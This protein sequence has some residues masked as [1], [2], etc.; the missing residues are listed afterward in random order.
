MAE[1]F[2]HTWWGKAWVEALEERAALDP[3]RLARGRTYARQDRVTSL[4][5][6]PGLVAASVRGSQR[7][8]YRTHIEVRTYDDTEWAKVVATIARRAGHTAA[9]LDGELEPGVVDDAREAGVE[10]LPARG[11]LRPR[12]SC[13]DSAGTCKHV[14]AVAYLV[15]EVLDD[16]P[17]QLFALRG[18]TREVFLTELRA[19]RARGAGQKGATD[20]EGGDEAALARLVADKA[21]GRGADPGELARQ[22]WARDRP[23][24]PSLPE[25]PGVPGTPAAWP[26]DPPPGAPFDTPGLLTLARDAAG[27]AWA[28]LR[29]DA[30][31]GLSLS[32]D[33]DLARR[34]AD[35]DAN[36]AAGAVIG[37]A[38]D[39]SSAP[40]ASRDLTH[41]AQAWR[42]GREAG[43]AML[44]ETPWRPSV[45]T[46][47]AA[48]AAVESAGISASVLTVTNNRITGPGF[49][50]R[51]SR[52][53]Q[54]WR[55]E[56][57]KSRWEIT[58]PPEESADDLLISG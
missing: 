46:M 16:D 48:R 53:G 45:A 49:Q 28:Q 58:A 57:R 6:E 14:A 18:R 23:A 33:A 52:Q 12:C 17:F 15:A 5:L 25:L 7:L 34:E 47:A 22:A 54:W 36:L 50:L 27:R 24:L 35:D 55:F 43:L 31:S 2:G 8:N 40:S 42:H 41:R 32:S 21:A 26:D 37:A 30:T 39:I 38:T 20:D 3:G 11:D 10:L 1:Q 9:V 51:L 4:T 56:K 19:H 44:G 29:G 13:P